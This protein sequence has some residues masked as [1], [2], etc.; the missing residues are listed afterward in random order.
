MYLLRKPQWVCGGAL[1]YVCVGVGR[2]FGKFHVG[3]VRRIIHSFKIHNFFLW[4]KGRSLLDY[5]GSI[6]KLAGKVGEQEC[7]LL[8]IAL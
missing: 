2:P 1:L 8:C 6:E 3:S 5:L 7:D 4:Y